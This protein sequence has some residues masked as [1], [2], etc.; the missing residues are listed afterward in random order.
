MG[1]VQGGGEGVD[2]ALGGGD[3]VEVR[4]EGGGLSLRGGAG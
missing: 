2:G 1:E 4:G 3:V